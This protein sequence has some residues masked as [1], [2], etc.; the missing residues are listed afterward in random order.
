MRNVKIPEGFI[1]KPGKA[2]VSSI[3]VLID[4]DNFLV[5]EL[6]MSS[7]Y[8]EPMMTSESDL[9]LEHEGPE[10]AL[11]MFVDRSLRPDPNATT[12]TELVLPAKTSGWRSQAEGGRYTITIVAWKDP[13]R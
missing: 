10:K 11:L 6:D 1:L 8:V 7:K 9:F 13:R 12:E 4:E 3:E 5:V 2:R